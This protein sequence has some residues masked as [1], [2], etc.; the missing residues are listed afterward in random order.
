MFF[1]ILEIEHG[2]S[3]GGF[4]T[5]SIYTPPVRGLRA[6]QHFRARDGC[7][8]P[9]ILSRRTSTFVRSKFWP[10]LMAAPVG[11][12]QD[13]AEFGSGAPRWSRGGRL[14]SARS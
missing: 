1:S 6:L 2:G 4:G 3:Y 14:I 10:C 8:G 12:S 5:R 11:P 7:R 13:V 9:L